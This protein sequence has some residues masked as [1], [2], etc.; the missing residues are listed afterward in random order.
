MAEKTILE[1][2]L[3]Q[4]STSNEQDDGSTETFIEEGDDNTPSQE[5][6][7][8]SNF[9]KLYKSNKEKEKALAEKEAIIAKQARELEAWKSENPEL[10]SAQYGNK[11][12][13]EME[14]KIF[15]LENPEAKSHI[16]TVQATA[17]EYGLP[18]D[19]AWKL[20]KADL[21]TESKTTSEFDFK[22]APIKVKKSM[23]DVTAEE[24]LKLSPAQQ[25]IWRK[26]VLGID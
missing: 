10:V 1:V 18:L 4:D 24:A 6:K 21:P 3:D 16:E 13:E 19:K 23:K 25:T 11:K 5:S 15:G 17:L 22:S 2:D 9:K 12:Q 20:V 8:E 26:T 14:I 7:N